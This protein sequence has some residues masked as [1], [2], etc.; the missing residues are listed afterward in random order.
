[1]FLI[2][3]ALIICIDQDKHIFNDMHLRVFLR[4]EQTKSVVNYFN[5]GSYIF[6]IRY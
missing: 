6:F 3:R 4:R 5:L 2:I 1:M